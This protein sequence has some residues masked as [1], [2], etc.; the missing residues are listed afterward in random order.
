MDL[1]IEMDNVESEINKQIMK[2]FSD[3]I[4]KLRES[5][6]L[7]L[8]SI[9]MQFNDAILDLRKDVM[10][11]K[12]EI[13]IMKQTNDVLEGNVA[14]VYEIINKQNEKINDLECHSI[15]NNLQIIGV[16]YTKD[17]DCVQVSKTILNSVL[18]TDV[19]IDTAHRTGGYVPNK[20]KQII[21][22]LSSIED[23][24]NIMKNSKRML[25]GQPCYIVEDLTRQDLKETRKWLHNIKILYEKGTNL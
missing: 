1:K 24:H 7:Q 9:K 16:Q 8:S 21:E 17:E 19:S 5:I 25:P 2:Q 20:S 12:Q 6:D 3:L 22:R 23:K 11:L 10:Q 15:K 18:N 14:S 13:N 4:E